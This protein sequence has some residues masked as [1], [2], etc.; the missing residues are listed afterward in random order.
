MQ[1]GTSVRVVVLT[2]QGS[3]YVA[4]DMMRAGA[5]DYIVKADL[6]PAVMEKSL[7]PLIVH[8]RTVKQSHNDAQEVMGR[9]RLLTP[10]EREVLDLIIQGQTNKQMA[11]TLNRSENTIKIHRSRVMQKLMCEHARGSGPHGPGCR[12]LRRDAS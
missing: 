5:D 10:R 12:P 11:Q 1:V 7:I 4:V 2:S 8:S 9:M 3:E 6:E